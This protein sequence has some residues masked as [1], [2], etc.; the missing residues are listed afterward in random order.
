MNVEKRITEKANAIKSCSKQS[1]QKAEML[2]ELQ[3][4]QQELVDFTF[5]T[6]KEGNEKLELWDVVDKLRDENDRLG[7]VADDAF[8]TFYK[9]SRDVINLIVS[10]ISGK[11]GESKAFGRVESVNTD[12]RLLKNI[13]LDDGNDRT[14]L[15][16]VLLTKKGAFIIEVKNTKREVVIDEEGNYYK[17]GR[18][19]YLKYNIAEKMRLREELLRGILD[20]N[21]YEDCAITSLLVFTNHLAIVHNMDPSVRVTLLGTLPFTVNDCGGDEKYSDKDLDTMAEAIDSARCAHEYEFEVDINQYKRDYATLI[22]Q[23]EDAQ[24]EE[25]RRNARKTRTLKERLACVFAPIKS[26]VAA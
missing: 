11:I 13:E 21:G 20:A 23:L 9:E 17:V 10:E 7:H 6:R 19:T 16:G 18:Y 14:E 22:V 4:L 24:A 1:Y 25:E 3:M 8:D 15:D 2:P 26:W 5:G 12:H